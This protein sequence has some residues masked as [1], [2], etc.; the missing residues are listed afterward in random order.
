MLYSKFT[1]KLLENAKFIMYLVSASEV[2]GA[3]RVRIQGP[4]AGGMNGQQGM[5]GRGGG[6]GNPGRGRGGPDMMNGNPMSMPG[7]FYGGDMGGMPMN[8]LGPMGPMGPGPMMGMGMDPMNFGRM[9]GFEGDFGMPNIASMG[10]GM[11][12]MANPMM[13]GMGLGMGDMGAAFPM[14]MPPRPPPPRRLPADEPVSRPGPTTRP[15]SSNRQYDD[16]RIDEYRDP[17]ARSGYSRYCKTSWPQPEHNTLD[18]IL[19]DSPVFYTTS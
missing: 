17:P 19:P 12:P 13:M 15:Y 10:M 7:P 6:R 5:M 9:G 18:S 8:G 1:F 2:C 4:S 16:D 3:A 14:A 11:G